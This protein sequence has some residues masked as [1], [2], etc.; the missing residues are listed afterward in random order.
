MKEGWINKGWWGGILGEEL[1]KKGVSVQVWK[2]QIVVHGW[3]L[4]HAG[5]EAK[6]RIHRGAPQLLYTG[7]CIATEVW[8]VS[9]E[10]RV[11][12]QHGLVCLKH[13][14]V[15]EVDF[16]WRTVEFANSAEESE[17]NLTWHL[18]INTPLTFPLHFVKIFKC[19][20]AHFKQK[21][22][23]SVINVFRNFFLSEDKEV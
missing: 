16:G 6:Q 5:G 9:G 10:L 8:R 13:H 4:A 11:E 21:Y 12:E 17:G 19:V 3:C 2:Y 1:R 22:T 18:K 14:I 7:S 20:H 15:P 23:Y